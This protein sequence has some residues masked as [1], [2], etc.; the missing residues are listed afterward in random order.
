M[1]NAIGELS[2]LDKR[3]GTMDHHDAKCDSSG[4]IIFCKGRLMNLHRHQA[5][6]MDIGSRRARDKQNVKCEPTC[7]FLGALCILM[8]VQPGAY[9]LKTWQLGPGSLDS[10]GHFS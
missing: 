4:D 2:W 6:Y 7:R 10:I 9:R 3:K 8:G 5:T 1:T